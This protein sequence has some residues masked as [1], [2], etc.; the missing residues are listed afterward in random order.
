MLYNK[1]RRKVYKHSEL[2][3]Q[4][5]GV[6]L[7]NKEDN[8]QDN[9][10]DNKDTEADTPK[11]E[12]EEIQRPEKKER[13]LKPEGDEI[14]DNLTKLPAVSQ[15]NYNNHK[16][17]IITS[18]QLVRSPIDKAVHKILNTLS[19][20][21][22]DKAVKKANYDELYHLGIKITTDKGKYL[23]DKRQNVS[24]ENYKMKDNEAQMNIPF[25]KGRNITIKQ[26]MNKTL[27][28]MGNDFYKYDMRDL[29]CQNFVENVLKSNNLDNPSLRKFYFQDAKAIIS[30]AP[31]YVKTIG[32]KITDIGSKVDSFLQNKL[33]I[34]IMEEGGI[35]LEN[36]IKR[37]LK[38]TG[39]R[40]PYM[41]FD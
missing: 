38:E 22:L 32:D 35:V 37:P 34:K 14:K 6:I 11:V 1:P 26:F 40:N 24:F 13:Q 17:E 16:N 4:D 12:V 29:N 3:L 18:L 5:G 25:N 20:G 21:L 9:K 28:R 33:G 31:S 2:R 19:L 10:E 30:S 7:D 27:D 15:R 36:P 41:N 23:A 39:L 8:K